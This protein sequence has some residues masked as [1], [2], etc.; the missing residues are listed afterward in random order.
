MYLDEILKR[1][2][3]CAEIETAVLDVEPGGRWRV[4]TVQC[5]HGHTLTLTLL[6]E[7]APAGDEHP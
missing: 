5:E 2:T 4:A 7:P 6:R 3:M 1:V